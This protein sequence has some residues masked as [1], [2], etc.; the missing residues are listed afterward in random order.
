M[1][2]QNKIIIG[3]IVGLA[4]VI[5]I[6][7]FFFPSV[8]KG[9]TSGSFGKADK[10]HQEQMTQADIQLR[11]DFTKDTAQLRQMVTGLIYFA[12]FTDNLSMT[13]DTCLVSYSLQGF[14]KDPAN[15]QAITLLKDYNTFLKNNTKTLASTTRMLAGFLLRDTASGSVDV[16][17][18][19]RDFANYV[20]QV[21]QKDSVLM[22]ALSK[23]DNYL[24]GNKTLQ[25]KT[26]E[27]RNLKA[28]RDQLVIKSTQ[29]LAMTGNKQ[30]L[31]NMLSYAVQSQAQFSGIG[32]LKMSTAGSRQLELSAINSQAMGAR[33]ALAAGNGNLSAGFSAVDLGLVYVAA[34]VNAA[35]DLSYIVYD[36]PNLQIIC[37]KA[38]E[39]QSMCGAGALQGVLNGSN[40]NL[41][42]VEVAAKNNI[43]IVLN[44]SLLCNAL[45]SS[46][47]N[48]GFSA[49]QM[50]VI[51]PAR[52][53]S[54]IGSMQS[55]TGINASLPLG[56]GGNPAL[57][58]LMNSNKNLQSFCSMGGMNGFINLQ[59]IA[60]GVKIL[61]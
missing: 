8:Y 12:L 6:V 61:E 34:K 50:N 19:I 33:N 58:A 7:S 52:D 39:L 24:V 26:D 15:S 17:N 35:S 38:S 37:C 60:L 10:Y 43:G 27:I 14:D 21:N 46:A 55:I 45:S 41:G 54:A 48:A 22:L 1:K 11:S 44:G 23:V 59:N 30:V 31:G 49:Q 53:L 40:P 32:A 28:I 29:F 9:L 20:N 47:L 5:L 3:V 2:K 16:E 56:S 42:I 13:I 25:K 36:R 18:N 4:V 51:I 57:Q